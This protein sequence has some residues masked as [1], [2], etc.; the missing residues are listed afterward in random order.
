LSGDLFTDGMLYA[1]DASAYREIPMAVAR[2]ASVK[3]IQLLIRFAAENHTTLI[4]RTAGTSLAGQV[5][6]NGIVV[7]VSRYFTH[8]IEINERDSFVRLQPG[9][10]LDELNMKLAGHGLFFGPET[11][12]SNRCSRGTVGVPAVPIH[13]IRQ[14]AIICWLLTAGATVSWWFSNL[15]VKSLPPNGGNGRECHLSQYPQHPFPPDNR[16]QIV[17]GFPDPP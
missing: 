8:V 6:G 12:T 1:T 11:S 15:S 9:V 13:Y 2:P 3:D 14:Y 17:E 10:V 5:V 7:D 4:P 16:I